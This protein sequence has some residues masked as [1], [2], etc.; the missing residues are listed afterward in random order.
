MFLTWIAFLLIVSVALGWGLALWWLYQ[1]INGNSMHLPL[2]GE[3]GAF[4]LFTLGTLATIVNFF[5]EIGSRVAISISII[6]ILLFAFFLIRSN[7]VRSNLSRPFLVSACMLS[8]F[9]TASLASSEFRYDAGLYHL[10][11]QLWIRNEP[12][13]FGLANLHDRFGFNSIE[14]PLEALFWL[15]DYNFALVAIIST[16]FFF[17]FF[18]AI[19]E[20]ILK[21]SSANSTLTTLFCI[22]SP[23]S[24]LVFQDYFIFALSANDSPAAI[25]YLMAVLSFLRLVEQRHDNAKTLSHLFSINVLTILAITMKLSSI[26]LLLL[27]AASYFVVVRTHLLSYRR[28]FALALFA[29]CLV[30]P[31][32][33]RG[34]VLSGCMA[35]PVAQTCITDLSWSAESKAGPIVDG[36]TGWAR[37][38]GP[39]YLDHVAGWGWFPS[40]IDRNSANLLSLLATSLF[41]I[42]LLYLFS[43][44]IFEADPAVRGL[45]QDTETAVVPTLTSLIVLEATALIIWFLKAPDMRFGI[46]PLHL[47]TLLPALT[48]FS[49]RKMT[50][51]NSQKPFSLTQALV[52]SLV[53]F[54]GFQMAGWANIINLFKGDQFD[55]IRIEPRRVE[56]L[57]DNVFGVRP[58]KG[59]QCWIT[60]QPCA[61]SR[62]RSLS[63]E[64]RGQ[65]TVFIPK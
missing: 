35:F 4:G 17:F 45:S 49:R 3:I 31:I 7:L 29:A 1:R 53:L 23:L 9:L 34:I 43:G 38:P 14:E 46:G 62:R 27:L 26:S 36:I 37:A 44:A 10:P 8:V 51:Q 47:F 22:L 6:G 13:A 60:K 21:E 33:I 65:Y 58:V 39:E 55:L 28:A 50:Q 41:L 42:G 18:S 20:F 12:I 52:L 11:M 32:V 63:V 61:P 64:R 57:S 24:F 15:P 54:G 2:W 25:L 40:W 19:L 48:V 5:S 56:I 59:N 30:A 16:L